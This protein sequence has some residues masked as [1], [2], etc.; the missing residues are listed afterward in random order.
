MTV[1]TNMRRKLCLTLVLLISFLSPSMVLAGALYGTIL[2]EKGRPLMGASV[3]VTMERNYKT[4][5][6][7]GKTDRSGAYRIVVP[8]TGRGTLTVSDGSGSVSIKV[9]VFN[10]SV[11]WNLQRIQT[12][13]AF[14]LQK[15]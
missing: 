10:N 12:D 1:E 8:G 5:H 3:T 7:T 13:G 6:G 9:Y 15:R 14:S 2:N 11:R 4:Y